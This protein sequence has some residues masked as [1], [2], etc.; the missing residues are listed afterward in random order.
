MPDAS[1]KLD[2]RCDICGDPMQKQADVYACYP[3]SHMIWESELY[4]YEEAVC[5][6]QSISIPS[7]SSP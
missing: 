7:N 2:V 4:K 3:C 5:Q 6:T 1:N